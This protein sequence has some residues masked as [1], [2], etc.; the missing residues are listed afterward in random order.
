MTQSSRSTQVIQMRNFTTVTLLL[1]H[2][3]AFAQA[4]DQE[5]SQCADQQLLDLILAPSTLPAT[6]ITETLVDKKID[7]KFVGVWCSEIT[8]EAPLPVLVA[9]FSDGTYAA[10]ATLDEALVEIGEWTMVDG[11]YF[12]KRRG[13]IS[14]GIFEPDEK[15]KRPYFEPFRVVRVNEQLLELESLSP[16]SKIRLHRVK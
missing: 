5:R 3:G 12:Q 14:D 11:Y 6:H 9:H 10:I 8:S 4:P 13:R 16:K 1:L 15:R 2:V 7:S